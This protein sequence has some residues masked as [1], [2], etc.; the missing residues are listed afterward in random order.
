METVIL[1][2]KEM[3]GF[4]DLRVIGYYKIRPGILQQNLGKY[5]RFKSADIWCK[6]FNTFINTLKGRK[7]EMKEN[8]PRLEL[9]NERRNMSE[10]EILDKYVDLDK[11]CLSEAG[12]TSYGCAILT[13]RNI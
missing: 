13:K 9:D 5:Y 12:K 7:E 4:L 2:P 3:L 11:S 6:Q 10:R 1:D 8:Y